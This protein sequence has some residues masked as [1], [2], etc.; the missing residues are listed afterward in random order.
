MDYQL[1]RGLLDCLKFLF[2]LYWQKLE[3]A[4]ENDIELQ[5]KS[6]SLMAYYKGQDDI[7]SHFLL[8]KKK[9]KR[10]FTEISKIEAKQSTDQRAGV[11]V[12]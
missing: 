9:S 11:R 8:L 6:L 3:H 4:K 7:D 5:E 2:F 10:S 1:E 12:I